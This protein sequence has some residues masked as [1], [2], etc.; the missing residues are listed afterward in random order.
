MTELQTLI[1]QI[2]IFMI[3]AKAI[4]H[5]R[6]DASYEKYLRMLLSAMILVQV[7][8][9]F[10][11]IFLGGDGSEL[12]KSVQQFQIELEESMTKA[13]QRANVSDEM[14]QQ[15]SLEKLQERLNEQGLEQQIQGEIQSESQ[16]T[17]ETG[18]TMRQMSTEGTKYIQK[19]AIAIENIEEIQVKLDKGAD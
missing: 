9:P 10:C 18:K 13:A 17:L 7:L 5:F 16:V 15:M 1:G 6:P 11:N 4:M 2:G 3:C 19:E 14:L 12:E 8:Q